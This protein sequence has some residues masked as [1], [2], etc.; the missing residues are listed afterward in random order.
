MRGRSVYSTCNAR[1]LRVKR[2]AGKSDAVCHWLK[3]AVN[4][5]GFPTRE[6]VF[7]AN[8]NATLLA[9]NGLTPFAAGQCPDLGGSISGLSSPT[10]NARA[11]PTQLI[12]AG[13]ELYRRPGGSYHV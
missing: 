8:I 1:A 5:L 3:A 2:R 12:V 7:A 13:D 11:D 6:R 9:L 4:A 10:A